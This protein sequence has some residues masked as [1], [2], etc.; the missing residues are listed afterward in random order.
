MVVAGTVAAGEGDVAAIVVTCPSKTGEVS[1]GF[2]AE[3]TDCGAAA[4][5]PFA[6]G[7]GELVW[8]CK[9]DHAA[10]SIVIAQPT[11]LKGF[12]IG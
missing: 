9:N 5:L 7:V 10:T 6:A 12:A 11:D 8:A 1:F 2:G 4:G 3:V